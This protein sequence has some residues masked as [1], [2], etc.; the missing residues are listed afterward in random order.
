MFST[1]QGKWERVKYYERYQIW[2]IDDI[3]MLGWLE[4]NQ[5][6]FES[7]VDSIRNCLWRVS[8]QTN[9]SKVYMNLLAKMAFGAA[10]WYQNVY[11]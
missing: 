6:I 7:A 8:I 9:M 11:V 1:W 2:F 5:L 4:K 10:G 3:A